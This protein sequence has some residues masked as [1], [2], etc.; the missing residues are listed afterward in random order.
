MAGVLGILFSAR[1]GAP[2]S[3]GVQRAK[4]MGN[5]AEVPAEMSRPRSFQERGSLA[6]SAMEHIGYLKGKGRA[7]SVLRGSDD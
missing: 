3:R 1:R 2:S 4:R 7:I 6:W 5:S